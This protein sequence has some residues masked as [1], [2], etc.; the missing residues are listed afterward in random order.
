M[1]IL[2]RVL[3]KKAKMPK[4]GSF[5]VIVRP[6]SQNPSQGCILRSRNLRGCGGA[7]VTLSWHGKGGIVERPF[8]AT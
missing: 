7:V 2:T 8:L 5:Q 4:F 1:P 3:P 6:K